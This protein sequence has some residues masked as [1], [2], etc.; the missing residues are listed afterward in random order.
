MATYIMIVLESLKPNMCFTKT[1]S[2]GS[3]V[4]ISR[5]LAHQFIH[6][7]SSSFVVFRRVKQLSAESDKGYEWRP[8]SRGAH[9]I[10]DDTLFTLQIR[11]AP[12]ERSISI[13]LKVIE[14]HLSYDIV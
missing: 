11:K 12:L 5:N 2:Q 13:S 1:V 14:R 9:P 3:V 8:S 6:P 7:L 10:S 4:Q